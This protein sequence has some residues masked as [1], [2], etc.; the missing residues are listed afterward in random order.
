MTGTP[1]PG[2]GGASL[3]F[4]LSCRVEALSL[5]KSRNRG[6]HFLAKPSFVREFRKERQFSAQDEN[7]FSSE[8]NMPWQAVKQ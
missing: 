6:T 3:S 2:D 5:A 8:E 4:C 1:L 7:Y